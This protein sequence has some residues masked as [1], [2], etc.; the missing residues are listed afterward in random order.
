LTERG[1]TLDE[2][3]ERSGRFEAVRRK[4]SWVCITVFV[5]S[6]LGLLALSAT[7]YWAPDNSWISFL[8]R[9]WRISG[10]CE[11]VLWVIPRVMR[12]G[13]WVGQIFSGRA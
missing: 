5:V 6:F 8:D 13:D 10:V 9:A 11:L 1:A 4:L 12:A 3:T 2:G 7:H